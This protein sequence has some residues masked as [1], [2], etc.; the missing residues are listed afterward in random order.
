[1]NKKH[2]DEFI[3]IPWAKY[4]TDY[5]TGVDC[6]GLVF[7]FYRDHLQVYL[8]PIPEFEF[9]SPNPAHKDLVINFLTRASFCQVDSP[10]FGDIITFGPSPLAGEHVGIFYDALTV[11]HVR[12]NKSSALEKINRIGRPTAFYRLGKRGVA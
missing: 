3:G 1:M 10:Q 2:A 9:N 4:G 7:L 12:E 11:L 5:T 6:V 8:P